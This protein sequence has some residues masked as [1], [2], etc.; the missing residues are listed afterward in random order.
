[1]SITALEL[2]T[3]DA[4]LHATLLHARSRRTRRPTLTTFIILLSSLRKLRLQRRRV[5]TIRMQ[6]L[7]KHLGHGD[8]VRQMGIAHH[9]MSACNGLF[10]VQ[11]PH[12]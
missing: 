3:N 7:G 9:D 10:L 11:A 2:F 5:D 12:M 4:A 8:K 6:A 1:M